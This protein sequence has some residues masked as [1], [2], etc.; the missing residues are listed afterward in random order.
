MRRFYLLR[1]AAAPLF[2]GSALLFVAHQ[3][4]QKVAQWSL[5]WA[6]AYL[7][8]VLCMPLLL[9]GLRLERS[10]LWARH[11]PLSGAEIAIATALV[12]AVS[13]G[14]FPVWSAQFTPDAFDVAAYALGGWVYGRWGQAT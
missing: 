9:H 6:D 12:A 2:Y 14:L 3:W 10:L 1:P 11:A 8:N 4:S 13:E 7:D 5:P